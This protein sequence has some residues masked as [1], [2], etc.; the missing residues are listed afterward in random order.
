M[1]MIFAIQLM[2]DNKIPRVNFLLINIASGIAKRHIPSIFFEMR[3]RG[4]KTRCF[5][6]DSSILNS[7]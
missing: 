3:P 5:P 7:G 2:S 4:N 6:C 1:H